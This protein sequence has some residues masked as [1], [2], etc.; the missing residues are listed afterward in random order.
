[1]TKLIGV[2]VAVDVAGAVDP[3]A[4]GVAVVAVEAA[5]AVDLV[6]RGATGVAVVAPVV[7]VSCMPCWSL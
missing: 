1:M 7:V 6:T 3:V 4:A 5:A 2:V